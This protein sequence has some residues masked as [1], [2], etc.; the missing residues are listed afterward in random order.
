[1]RISDW[2]SD[3]CSSD[4]VRPRSFGPTPCLE[5]ARSG[6]KHDSDPEFR[7]IGGKSDAV[8][9]ATQAHID[10][11]QRR[12]P[13]LRQRDRLFGVVGHPAAA[14]I[15]RAHVCTPVTNAHRVCRHQIEN[16]KKHTTI[17]HTTHSTKTEQIE[18]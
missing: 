1:M 15:G 2:S 11:G 8:A 10:Q 18:I 14:E 6:E 4:L 12:T 5:I 13:S 16:K 7:E 9:V 3:V 17:K